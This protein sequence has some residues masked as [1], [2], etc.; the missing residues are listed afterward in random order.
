MRRRRRIVAAAGAALLVAVAAVAAA[1]LLVPRLA[2][3]GTGAGAPATATGEGATGDADEGG[4]EP[5]AVTERT[6]TPVTM[7]EAPTRSTTTDDGLSVTAPEAFL[8]SS[9]LEDVREEISALEEGRGAMVCVVLLDLETRRGITYDAD[10]PMYPASSIKAAYC[11]WVM[12]SHGGAA[13]RSAVVEDCLVNSS[14]DAFH[15]LIDAFGLPAYASWLSAHGAPSAART[16]GTYFYPDITA[17]ELASV[18]EEI[19]RYGTSDDAGGSELAGYLART[20]SSPIAAELRDDCEV[21]AKPGWYPADAADLPASNDA[22]VVFSDEGPYVMVVMTD[23]GSDLDALRPLISALDAAHERM[24][25][26]SVA[27]Y[28]T[29]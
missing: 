11:T 28:V 4:E 6:A 13:G 25:G 10:T 12:E 7:E 24:C 26:D 17:S 27:Y 21:W 14:N 19:W 18:W 9:E 8:S 1:T 3:D 29:D 15:E 22:G 16:A 23:I 2:D 5:P 20:G